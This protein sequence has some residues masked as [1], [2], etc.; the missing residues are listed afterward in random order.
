MAAFAVA[1]AAAVVVVAAFAV[2]ATV[3]VVVAFA[4]VAA[5]ADAIL[6]V[7]SN[8][9]WEAS[10]LNARIRKAYINNN[11]K[12]GLIGPDLDLNYSYTKISNSL[13]ALNDINEKKSTFS[14]IFYNAKNPIIIIGTSS[15]N[16]VL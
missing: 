4:L 8:P 13:N 10:V 14:E 3:A 11:C 6:L 15:I 12:V 16:N 7:G 5:V 1:V 2:A 9:R